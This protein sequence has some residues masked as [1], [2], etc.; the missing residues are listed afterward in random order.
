MA[1]RV[2]GCLAA[3]GP[4]QNKSN[5]FPFRVNVTRSNWQPAD[6]VLNTD[7]RAVGKETVSNFNAINC[8]SARNYCYWLVSRGARARARARAHTHTH[9]HTQRGGGGGRERERERE[10]ERVI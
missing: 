7:S 5:R 4:P 2:Y 8:L 10:R 3:A 6:T 1:M 9:T